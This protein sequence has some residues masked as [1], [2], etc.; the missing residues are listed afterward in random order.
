M[1]IQTGIFGKIPDGREIKFFQVDNEKGVKI[2]FINY[3]AIITAINM[4]DKNGHLDNIVCGFDNLQGYLNHDYLSQYPY[5]GAVIGRYCNRI[6][7]GHLEIEGKSFPL[8][9]NNGSNHLHG[10][11][12]GFDR[13]IWDAHIIEKHDAAGV[14]FSYLSPHLE[15]NYPGNLKI[16]CIYLLSDSGELSMEYFAETDQTTV[17]NIT[18]HTYFNLTGGRTNILNHEL[19]LFADNITV[20]SGQIPTG[21]IKPVAETVYDFSQFKNFKSG[22]DKLPQ[23]YDDNYVL[24]TDNEKMKPACILREKSSSRQIEIMT[25]QPGLQLYTGYWI[26]ELNINGHEQFGSFSGIAL[27]TQHFPDSVHHPHF[28]STLLMPGDIFNEKTIYK[29]SII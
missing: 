4:P 16:K 9:T 23:G 22:L 17:V 25:T 2:N 10:G 1:E 26:P 12:M 18:N 28:P 11:N 5:F 24:N 27:E 7:K 13:K 3:G 8:E 6:A 20:M 21:E 15:E 19:K 14:E 29:F